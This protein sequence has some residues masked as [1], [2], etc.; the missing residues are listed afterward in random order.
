M[1][2]PR[3]VNRFSLSVIVLALVLVCA[4][5]PG[6][7]QTPAPREE[8]APTSIAARA[9]AISSGPR[10]D[11]VHINTAVQDAT[12]RI[13]GINT[14]T[15]DAFYEW[16]GKEWRPHEFAPTKGAAPVALRRTEEGAVL[17]LWRFGAGDK[18]LKDLLLC[19][20][21]GSSERVVARWKGE[22]SGLI[23]LSGT[24]RATWIT[25]DGRE[26]YR[27][28]SGTAKLVYS[29]AR[30]QMKA[31]DPSSPRGWQEFNA[32]EA[33]EDARGH[34]LFWSNEMSSSFN[35][36][37]LRGL[38]E[39]DGQKWTHHARLA[40]VPDKAF[41]ALVPRDA[42][43]FW[44]AV[45]DG[46]L[47][48]LDE[49]TLA[50][51]HI[52]EPVPHAFQQIQKIALA[53]NDWFVIA[54]SPGS[55][56]IG[57]DYSQRESDVWRLRGQANRFPQA[58]L[59]S[60]ASGM[61]RTRSGEALGRTSAPFD[62]GKMSALPL[63]RNASGNLFPPSR[64]EWV[65]RGLDRGGDSSSRTERP[66]ALTKNGLWL[67]ALAGG[68]WWLPFEGAPV[69]LDWRRGLW[70]PDVS[71]LVLQ[72]DGQ[73]LAST[74]SGTI[75][76][77]RVFLSI[78]PV[79]E[80]QTFMTHGLVEEDARHHL[81]RVSNFASHVVEEWDG[82]RWRSHPVPLAYGLRHLFYLASDARGRL[83]FLPDEQ[84]GAVAVFQPQTRSWQ[85]FPNF[86]AAVGRQLETLGPREFARASIGKGKY[87]VPRFA[88]PN[89]IASRSASDTLFYFDGHVWRHWTLKDIT[90]D[91]DINVDAW[92]ETPYFDAP[93]VLKANI[94]DKTW[95]WNGKMWASSAVGV[96][97]FA[98]EPEPTPPPGCGI[99]EP[100]SIVQDS[101]GAIWMTKNRQLWKAALGLCA[102][103]LA[104]G[105]RHPLRDGRVLQNVNLDGRGHILL[106]T[107][108]QW[109]GESH[110][111][112]HAAPDTRLSVKPEGAGTFS[113][114]FASSSS[115]AQ[116]DKGWFRWRM[117]GASWSP[118]QRDSSLLLEFVPS[119]THRFEVA[120]LDARLSLDPTPAKVQLRVALSPQAQ[121]TKFLSMLRSPDYATREAGVR[122]FARQPARATPFLQAARRS[123]N[124]ELKWWIDAAL[125]E[126]ESQPKAP[127]T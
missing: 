90:R 79:S 18:P 14:W 126:M 63:V 62:G 56:A 84:D 87:F 122:A 11:E 60:R 31:G 3:D 86:Q 82:E 2:K 102:P 32:L 34:T 125:E 110:W 80:P 94:S 85:L 53:G 40:G 5:W 13:W 77:L 127:G 99:S 30:S 65:V 48:Q 95:S 23:R 69:H 111:F 98:A 117:D 123:A 113:L 73:L 78:A 7:F 46:G 17:C 119:G 12:G 59:K 100:D 120:A 70:M 37:S 108:P 81:W 89:R 66:L 21:K 114:R 118:P 27:V 43:S 19:E 33:V 121:L 10:A 96:H 58:A 74:W 52:A 26:I 112:S 1:V 68:A 42:H 103:Q 15:N 88:P 109:G 24:R 36:L 39:F 76:D 45:G 101:S 28:R 50:G 106:S 41:T 47:F 44:L 35:D 55:S 61:G 6:V 92:E 116:R 67:G 38:L 54:N 75:P 51:Q 83:W 25:L 124:A 49:G 64:F 93:G 22:V 8:G 71:N 20:V 4:L 72:R 29:I 115:S 107:G 57:G 104:P 16:N 9:E 105:E 97:P 91:K